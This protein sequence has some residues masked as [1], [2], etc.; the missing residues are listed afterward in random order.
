MS[1][2][3][4]RA[5]VLAFALI[6][7]VSWSPD[8]GLAQGVVT[9]DA[10]GVSPLTV[11]SLN[12]EMREDV[13]RILDGIRG[14]GADRADV[15]L[16]QEVVQAEGARSVGDQIAEALGLEAAYQPSFRIEGNRY[17]GLA[18]LSRF[19]ITQSR[20]LPLKRFS[21][22]FRSR[23]RSALAV[24]L[25]TPAGPFNTYNVHLDTRIN[26]G[27][28]VDQVAD[29]V[30]DMEAVP[31]RALVAGDFN[32]NEYLWVFHTIP[33]PFLGRQGSGLERYMAKH[34]L[35][36]AFE[37]GSTHDT[38]RMRLDWIFLRDLQPTARAI[39]PMDISDHHA[40][41]VTMQ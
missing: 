13:A 9:P 38:L 3:R 1:R 34:G 6:A 25:E 31:G 8:S 41:V 22:M 23:E 11:V 2:R 27:D 20:A 5:A 32:T 30:K 12:L 19:P 16:L 28:R 18:T 26:G 29:I 24:T 15:L 17:V 21:L 10:A 4:A 7:T 40:L 36:S 37:R 33:L 39:H 35:R 14:V